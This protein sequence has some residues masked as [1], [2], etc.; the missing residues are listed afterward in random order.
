MSFDIDIKLRVWICI[1][2]NIQ[3]EFDFFILSSI[4]VGVM[5]L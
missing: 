3:N 5:P 1:D 4:P 2:I